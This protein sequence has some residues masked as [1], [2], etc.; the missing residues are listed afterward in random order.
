MNPL[1]G[2][3]GLG[4]SGLV[5]SLERNIPLRS[6][7]NQSGKIDRTSSP[8][9]GRAHDMSRCFT[10]LAPSSVRVLLPFP[11]PCSLRRPSMLARPTRR[12][13]RPARWAMDPLMPPSGERAQA[14]V[15]GLGDGGGGGLGDGSGKGECNGGGGGVRPRHAP[16]PARLSLRRSSSAR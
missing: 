16:P 14:A 3:L 12:P 11:S 2:V 15:D 6:C 13:A 9:L 7:T 8:Y 5:W 1:L 4:V 10:L